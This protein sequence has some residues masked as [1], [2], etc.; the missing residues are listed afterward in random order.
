MEEGAAGET[1]ET[2]RP[3]GKTIDVGRGRAKSRSPNRGRSRSG[4]KKVVVVPHDESGAVITGEPNAVV[5]VE[6]Q[7]TGKLK[8][9]LEPP[10]KQQQTA[11]RSPAPR[12]HQRASSAS[13]QVVARSPSLARKGRA[14]SGPRQIV[15]D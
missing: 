14:S 9:K 3:Y 11:T 15:L 5:R 2:A 13:V 12:A 4:H 7:P 8:E 10:A 6:S 1:E